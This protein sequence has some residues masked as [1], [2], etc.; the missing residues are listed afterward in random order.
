MAAF[1]S[2][3]RRL[4]NRIDANSF[5]L[6]CS[7]VVNLFPKR[8]DPIIVSDRFSEFHVVAERTRPI[9][10]EVY[11]M[12]GV[13]GV[14]AKTNKE[15]KFEPFYRARDYEGQS[16]AYYAV[17]RAPRVLTAREKKF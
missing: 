10:F 16:G 4:D 7:P 11:E 9:D 5:A 14:L 3:D 15:Q 1:G 17:H 6:F 8:L 13:V 12:R 2:T